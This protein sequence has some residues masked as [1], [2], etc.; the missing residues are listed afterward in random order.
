MSVADPV[1]IVSCDKNHRDFLADSTS[2]HGLR[3]ICCQTLAAAEV[4]LARE[5]MSLVFCEE[6]LPDGHFAQL[7]HKA[8]HHK[9]SPPI[10]VVSRRDDW[11]AY[12][13]AMRLGAFDYVTLP[14]DIG[15]LEHSLC[16]AMRE[17]WQRG[18]LPMVTAG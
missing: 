6:E 18:K 2:K 10:V 15:E 1:L 17:S 14:P 8:F 12:L 11:D 16:G 4:L 3:P 9:D 5:S 7:V 13:R